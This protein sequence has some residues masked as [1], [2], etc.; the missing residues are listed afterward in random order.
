MTTVKT[1]MLNSMA[2]PDFARALE[3]HRAWGLSLLDVKDGIFGK[4]ALD[5]TADEALAAGAAVREKELSVYCISS[6]LFHAEIEEGEEFFRRNHLAKIP[7]ALKI[8][9]AL[10]PRVFRLLAAKTRERKTTVNAVEYIAARHPWVFD[11][12]RE[13]IDM[14]AAAGFRVTIENEVGTCIFSTAEEID[15]FFTRLD[16]ADKVDFTWDAANLWQM[17]TFP[18][19]ETYHR[20]RHLIGYYH[21]KGGRSEDGGNTLRY[22]SSLADAGWPVKDVTS[23]VIEDGIVEAICLNPSHG[24]R[25]DGEPYDYSPAAYKRDIDFI[26]EILRETSV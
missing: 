8:A 4:G 3:I 21:V 23:R 16:R 17:G 18:D 10:T 11:V 13:A 7:H 2:D 5:L 12:Y 19:I 26:G 14:F 20:L 1:T 25:P 9:A 15:A 6:V 22:C 24:K